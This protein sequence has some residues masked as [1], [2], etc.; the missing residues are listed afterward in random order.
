MY[1]KIMVPLDGSELAE[2]AIPPARAMA[3]AFK[4][5]LHLT[6]VEEVPEQPAPSEWDLTVGDFL[7]KKR[8]EVQER[9]DKLAAP[10]RSEGIE[11]TTAILPLGP[12]VARLLE[13]LQQQKADLIVLH[14]HGRSG[15]SRMIWGSVAERL[16]RQASCP[17][18]IVHA[19][20]TA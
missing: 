6:T 20:R 15:L 18:M 12:T 14:S 3:L 17:V 1:Q 2:Y 16:T 4:A 7:D 5:S 13:E 10:L 9:L 8:Q 11:V 19:Q